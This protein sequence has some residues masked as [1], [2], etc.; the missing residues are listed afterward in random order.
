MKTYIHPPRDRWAALLARP[1]QRENDSIRRQV[2]EIVEHVRQHGDTALRELSSR[3]D[4]VEPTGLAVTEAEIT[5][6]DRQL[7]DEL[8]TAIRQARENIA[9]FHAAQKM[10]PVR[11][12]TRPGIQCE[13]RSVPIRSVGL[14]VPGG[15]APLFSTVLMLAVPAQIAGCREITL[16][17][18]PRKDGTVAPEILWTAQLCGVTR[19]FKVGG[20]QAIAAMAF[21]TQTVP[22]ADKI[23]GPGN[24]YVMA[25]K[26]LLGLSAVAIDMPAGPSEVMVLADDTARAEFAAADLLSQAE[27]GPDSQA[28][29]VT[30]SA[31]LATAVETEVRKQLAR[32]GRAEIATQALTESRIFVVGSEAEMVA[33]ANLYAAEH[34]IVETAEPE[35]VA[36]QIENAGSI[37]LGHYSPESAGDYASGTNHTLPTSGWAAAYG[38]VNIDSFCKKITLQRLTE[39]GLRNIGATVERMASAEGLDAHRNAVRIRLDAMNHPEK[40]GCN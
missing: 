12:E 3:F 4:G 8:K 32:L 16:C 29:L 22:K 33:M 17:T 23:F 5:A 38:G 40:P 26:Q 13:Q 14:Y 24:R 10:E 25:A 19:I 1:L 7:S 9:A 2:E 27:H 20:A 31:A 39:D 36:E 35:A 34:L 21:G 15:S 6:A 18:P 30:T 28:I 11:V 37:F